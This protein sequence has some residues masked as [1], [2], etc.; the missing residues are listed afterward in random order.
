MPETAAE[1]LKISPFID[2]PMI[3]ADGKGF[4]EGRKAIVQ[5]DG[6]PG[7][8]LRPGRKGT[9]ISA[10]RAGPFQLVHGEASAGGR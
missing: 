5:P 7:R 2:G 4:Y 1:G 10:G 3:Q 6:R 8:E 9:P